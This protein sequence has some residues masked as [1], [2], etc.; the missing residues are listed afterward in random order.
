MCYLT[1]TSAASPKHIKSNKNIAENIRKADKIT[2]ANIFFC[3]E[4]TNMQKNE[5]IFAGRSCFS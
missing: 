4:I 2:K 3:A 1:T 5:Q